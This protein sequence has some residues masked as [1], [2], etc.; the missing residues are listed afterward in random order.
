MDGMGK[1][2]GSFVEFNELL[3][4]KEGTSFSTISGDISKLHG[5]IKYVITLDARYHIA[6]RWSKNW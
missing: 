6:Y 2:K 4:G 5:K 3:L 1:K